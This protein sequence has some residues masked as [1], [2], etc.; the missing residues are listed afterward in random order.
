MITQVRFLGVK[1]YNPRG[2]ENK[3]LLSVIF[4]QTKCHFYAFQ[5]TGRS[6]FPKSC[7]YEKESGAWHKLAEHS[8]HHTSKM[9]LY[10]YCMTGIPGQNCKA[11]PR[12][13]RSK[14][15]ETL[16]TP[17]WSASGG[18]F[19]LCVTLHNQSPWWYPWKA[20]L[21]QHCKLITTYL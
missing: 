9:H 18:R 14:F 8:C 16:Q 11:W 5:K 1:G 19:C 6:G 12:K 3:T 17:V 21:T 15:C 4:R 2:R 20:H 7:G 13:S 10:V